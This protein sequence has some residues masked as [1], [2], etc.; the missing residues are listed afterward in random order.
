MSDRTRELL[1]SKSKK[2]KDSDPCR[3]EAEIS[4]ECLT[5][6]EGSQVIC[7]QEIGNYATCKSFWHNVKQYRQAHNIEPYLPPP[8]ER[9]KYKEEFFQ[10]V[11]HRLQQQKP[12][13]PK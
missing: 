10:Q 5:E 2:S 6:Y 12:P 3:K 4:L 1:R 9:S 13:S 7:Y 11:R 8:E